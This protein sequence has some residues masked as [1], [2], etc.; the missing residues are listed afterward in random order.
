MPN[1]FKTHFHSRNWNIWFGF[2]RNVPYLKYIPFSVILDLI[3]DAVNETFA[4]PS[5]T[6]KVIYPYSINLNLHINTTFYAWNSWNLDN[7]PS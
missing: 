4:L 5:I 2:N 6:M 3:F 1:Y 7:I